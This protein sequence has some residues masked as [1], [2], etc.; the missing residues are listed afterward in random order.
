[1]KIVVRAG[2]ELCLYTSRSAIGAE[3]R[4][5][6]A[7]SSRSPQ[8]PTAMVWPGFA[9]T[10]K[11]PILSPVTVPVP[12][13]AVTVLAVTAPPNRETFVS[14][15]RPLLQPDPVADAESNVRNGCD[16]GY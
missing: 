10:V 9:A 6:L 11:P 3:R 5:L 1:M 13:V 4:P 16:A 14:L 15:T 7:P 2:S 8:P 12:L